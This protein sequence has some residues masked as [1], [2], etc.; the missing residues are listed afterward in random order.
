MKT[1]RR[2]RMALAGFVLTSLAAS[3]SAQ[4]GS[5]GRIG[6]HGH[7]YTMSNDAAGN[8]VLAYV[9]GPA[10]TLSLAQTLPTSGLG[11]SAGLGTQGAVTLSRDGMFLFAVNAGSGSVSTFRVGG[12]G[13]ERAS[14]VPSGGS[15]PISVTERAGVVYVLNGGAGGNITGFRNAN[16]VLAPLADGVRGLSDD[17]D[18]GPAEVSFDRLGRTVVVTEKNTNRITTYAAHADGTLG[19]PQITPSAGMTPFGFAF[20]AANHL[21][22][23]EADGGAPDASALS[24]YR[25][26]G[27]APHSPVVVSGSVGTRQTAACW[28]AVTPDGRLAFTTNTG[29]G[30]VSSFSVDERG[31]LTLVESVAE[32][33]EGS[34]PIDVVV[35]PSGVRLF[36]LNGPV[37]TIGSFAISHR[38]GLTPL[39]STPVPMFA[40]GLAID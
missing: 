1:F 39:A 15:T 24:S 37:H 31:A 13:L 21:L 5:D 20:D 33:T 4:V 7:V 19:Q 30:S 16:G 11:T 25:F 35:S 38:G 28:T 32:Q 18:V 3:A 36:V 14:T 40:V 29:S 26:K 6:G 12:H 17:I 8:A 22:V 9:R 34:A 10:G 27:N 23:S 2:G